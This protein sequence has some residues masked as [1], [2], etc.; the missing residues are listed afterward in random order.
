[1]LLIKGKEDNLS[2]LSEKCNFSRCYCK[3]VLC[4]YA[5]LLIFKEFVH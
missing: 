4:W 3:I 2:F 1:M 5:D